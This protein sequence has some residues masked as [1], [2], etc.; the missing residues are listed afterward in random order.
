MSHKTKKEKK[1]QRKL[2]LEKAISEGKITLTENQVDAPPIE[3]E[4]EPVK[5][6]EPHRIIFAPSEVITPQPIVKEV[7]WEP[8][9]NKKQ[10]EEMP[11]KKPV[12]SIKEPLRPEECIICFTNEDLVESLTKLQLNTELWYEEI[13]SDELGAPW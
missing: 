3:S 13:Y 8:K 1:R 4:I 6:E 11:F 10:V 12:K 2:E 5:E 7:A 9:P